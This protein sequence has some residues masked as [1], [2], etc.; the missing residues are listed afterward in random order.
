[1]H[2]G[3]PHRETKT[4][5]TQAWVGGEPQTLRNRPPP[6][7][8]KKARRPRNDCAG[9]FLELWHGWIG[10][11]LEFMQILY[12]RMNQ[13]N[14][15]EEY[16]VRRQS[17]KWSS[18]IEIPISEQHEENS[19]IHRHKNVKIQDTVLVQYA[20]GRKQNTATSNNSCNEEHDKT[21]HVQPFLLS[22]CSIRRISRPWWK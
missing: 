19:N 17:T 14:A 16:Q 15:S 12:I 11:N 18:F 22:D 4:D 3:G 20:H 13:N 6:T 9:I 8:R 7:K 2:E 10:R 1:M 5:G 21:I